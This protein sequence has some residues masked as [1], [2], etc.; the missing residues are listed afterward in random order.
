MQLYIETGS[1]AKDQH[2]AII[3]KPFL[4]DERDMFCNFELLTKRTHF[5]VPLCTSINCTRFEK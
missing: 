4:F 2:D 1:D 5:I 3:L